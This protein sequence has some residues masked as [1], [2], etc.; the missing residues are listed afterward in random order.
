MTNITHTNTLQSSRLITG[1]S[2]QS[3]SSNHRRED[4]LQRLYQKGIVISPSELDEF[5]AYTEKIRRHLLVLK[6]T[7]QSVQP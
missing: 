2:P 6:A 1:K 3:K 7:S 5:N 4:K